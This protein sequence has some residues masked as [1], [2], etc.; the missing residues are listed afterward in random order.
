MC[1]AVTAPHA[2]SWTYAETWLPEDA[3]VTEARDKA[4][5]L[6]CTPVGRGAATALTVIAALL[7]AKAVVEVGT[8]AGISG[9]A[10]RPWPS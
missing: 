6:G 3:F 8:G 1:A 10:L 2:S 5:E 7:E 4:E 9:L